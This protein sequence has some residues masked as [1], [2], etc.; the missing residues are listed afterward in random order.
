MA[1][2]VQ[3][4]AVE[5][6]VHED[7][8]L[9]NYPASKPT[10]PTQL[11]AIA[12]QAGSFLIVIDDDPTGSQSVADVPVLTSW[13]QPDLAW[14]MAQN[15][16]VIFV[17]TNSRSVDSA[18]A[19]QRN[20]EVVTNATAVAQAS[21]YRLTF[22]SRS[23]S[24]LRGHFPQETDAIA[25]ASARV[26]APAIDGIV[27]VPAFPSAGRVTV[28]GV[29]YLRS[30]G[31]LIPVAQ[32]QFAKDPSFSFSHSRLSEYVEEKTEGRIRSTDVLLIDLAL[33]RSTP[34]AIADH[35]DSVTNGR[36][37]V[38]DCITDDDL[39]AL[40][41]GLA[42]AEARGK[43]FLYRTGPAFI[44]ARI[45]QPQP[46]PLDV[47]GVLVGAEAREPGGLVVVGSHVDLTNRQLASLR[48]ARPDMLDIEL[49]V[50]RRDEPG[51]L[52]GIV[53][54][55]VHEL[56]TGD[57]IVRTSR[58]LETGSDAAESLRIARAVSTAVSGI[59][60]AVAT[61]V[62]PRFVIAK[63]GITSNDVASEGLDIRR[64]TIRG[65]LLP[66]LV[67]LWQPAE[68]LAADI[69]YV[70]FPGNVGDDDALLAVVTKLSLHN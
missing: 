24:I 42:V 53:D 51:Y 35:L 66:G 37:I 64:G 63:G 3:E 48:L 31:E 68:G 57:V 13:S 16:P 8:L 17:L 27:L 59:V 10:P 45:G 52:S 32:T 26:G 39:R 50:E 67:S 61:A 34:E 40:C 7:T 60:H 19:E 22:L 46:E 70:V 49:A 18:T 38:A 21:G 55:I 15:R 14:A 69:P 62:R 9:A 23:D 43:V 29:H 6:T 20:E 41:L 30:A 47:S 54:T 44:G 2:S 4:S 5:R 12:S 1:S 56:H 36:V 65:P 58:A 33:I 25:R 11:A 28:G